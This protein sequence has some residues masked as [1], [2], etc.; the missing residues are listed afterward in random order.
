MRRLFKA[1]LAAAALVGTVPGYA[2]DHPDLSGIWSLPFQVHASGVPMMGGATP[3]LPD[4]QGDPKKFP[5]PTLQQLSARIDES[6]KTHN[7]NPLFGMPPPIPAP[8]TAEGKKA[9]AAID[10]KIERER[11][12]NCY[13][14]NVFSRVGGGYQTVQ[15]IQGI[16]ALAIISDGSAP[17]RVVY[18]DGRQ[19]GD[20]VPQW[21][22][23]S[24]GHWEGETLK[25]DTARI[26]GDAL[27]QGYPISADAKLIE[28]FHLVDGGKRLEVDATFEDPAFYSQTLHRVMYLERHPELQ[29]TDYSC[30]E[31]KEDMIETASHAGDKQP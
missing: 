28:V 24:I 2:A 4:S 5:I 6:V 3:W 25:V 30:E 15:I 17:G 27:Q 18:L 12:L 23:H 11:E 21:N 26:R 20:A 10:P 1:G 19:H 8:L 31:G 29:L 16:K 14:S 13:P 7:G 22:G 9:A